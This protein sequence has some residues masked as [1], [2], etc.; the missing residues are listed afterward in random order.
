MTHENTNFLQHPTFGAPLQ[1]LI[2][3]IIAKVYDR[4]VPVGTG[5]LIQAGGLMLTA[6]HVLDAATNEAVR[7]MTTTGGFAPYVEIYALYVA[8]ESHSKGEIGGLWPIDKLWLQEQI[9]VALC[10]LKPARHKGKR[11]TWGQVRLSPGIPK[12]GD[13]IWGYGYFGMSGQGAFDENSKELIRYRQH[14]AFTRGVVVEVHPQSRD[15]GLLPFPC[16]RTDARFDPGMSGGP[17]V[18]KDGAVGGV[19]CSSS[20]PQ[21]TDDQHVSYV[22]MIWPALGMEIEADA[23]TGSRRRLFDLANEGYVHTDSTLSQV[24][25]LADSSEGFRLVVED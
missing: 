5:F 10:R 22:S 12:V 11:V 25:V 15:K 1:Q 4:L 7:R 20:P 6:R 21:D 24:H 9:D 16:F 3:P 13:E 17:V 8:N 18:N 19:I 2:M 23:Q 14:S